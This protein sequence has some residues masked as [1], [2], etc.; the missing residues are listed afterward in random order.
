MTQASERPE[1]L[2]SDDPG[3]WQWAWERGVTPWDRGQAARP[4][5]EWLASGIDRPA[6]GLVLRVAVLGAGA[7]HDALLF[8]R[9]GHDVV[10]FDFAPGAIQTAER[11]AREA[12]LSNVRFEQR[13]IFDLP[14]AYPGSFHLVVEHTCFTAIAPFRREEYARMVRAVLQPNG[15]FVGV[16][17]A[18]GRPGGPPYSTS[19]E[20]VERLFAPLLA[21]ERIAETPH[22][23]ADRPGSELLAVMRKLA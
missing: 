16:F 1:G 19:R 12:G 3:Y 11:K 18:G 13:N 14:A 20:E 23:V 7:G 21:I 2:T 5:A 10:G 4:L 8:A 17:L 6:E 22:S 15:R 9:A